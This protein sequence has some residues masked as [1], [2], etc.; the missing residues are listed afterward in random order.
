MV[1]C[2]FCIFNVLKFGLFAYGLLTKK[3]GL[4][5]WAMA[6]TVVWIGH[7]PFISF[8]SDFAQHFSSHIPS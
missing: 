3:F 2:L 1:K 5:I 7:V 4:L 6:H 8:I